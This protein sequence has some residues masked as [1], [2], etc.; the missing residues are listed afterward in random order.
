MRRR[1][2]TPPPEPT[3][4]EL[5]ERAGKEVVFVEKSAEEL[6]DALLARLQRSSSLSSPPPL[7]S[8]SSSRGGAG[9][10]PSSVVGTCTKVEKN[11]Y[12][13]TEE[14]KPEDVR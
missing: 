4:A 12:R 10:G 2:P 9:D 3:T 11:Y 14:P 7:S 1:E 6:R 5:W 8:S 13:L